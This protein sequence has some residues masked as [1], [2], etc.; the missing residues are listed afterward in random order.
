MAVG[1]MKRLVDVENSLNVVITGRKLCKAPQGIAERGGIN[2]G[3]SAGFPCVDVEAEEL[4]AGG[5]SFAKLKTRFLGVIGGDAVEDVAVERF[6]IAEGSREGN[7]EAEF[8]AGRLGES[9]GD[10][11]KASGEKKQDSRQRP[12]FG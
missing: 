3:G 12:E 4:S 2:D 6:S 9:G 7:V 10:S 1:P 11:E 5:F 8:A